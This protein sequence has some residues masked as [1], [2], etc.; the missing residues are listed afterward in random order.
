MSDAIDASALDALL[1]R[2][3]REVDDG[4]L[5]SC[6]L[7]V[8]RHGEIVALE[9]FGDADDSSRYVIFSCTKALIAGAVWLQLAD[10][11][12]TLEQPVA[13]LIPGFGDN[14][15]EAVTVEQ[16]LV[17]QSGFPTAPLPL[18]T[19]MGRRQ[20]LERYRSW[21]LNWEP[22]TR[23]EYHPTSAHWIL[24]ELIETTSGTDYRHFVHTRVLDPLGL[25]RLRLGEPADRQGD[26]VDL[27]VR[28]EPPTPAELHAVLG[29]E[30]LTLDQMVGEVTT[31]ALMSFNQPDVRAFGVPGGGG[32]SGA[33]DL[34]LYYQAL[35][36]NPGGLWDDTWLAAGTREVHGDLPEP[37]FGV[38]SHRT[39]GLTMAGQGSTA[40][41]RGYGHT[42]S[43]RAF[44]HAGAGG[45]IAFADPDTGISFCYLTN[46]LD[47]N[48]LREHRRTAGLASRAGVLAAGS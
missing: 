7:A 9:T 31:D 19:T 22:G 44:G 20:R 36:A 40:A 21:R 30:G 10:G 43:P 47:A 12:F 39:L 13:E 18:A 2:A 28:G 46:G 23:F 34:A 33:A 32:I 29:V 37:L 38:P 42:V 11:A 6:Q 48:V 41:L 25:D 26:I 15:K 3:R 17:H 4:L 24:A 1:T 35:L 5:P 8:A 27:E 45:Q 14:G 16:L